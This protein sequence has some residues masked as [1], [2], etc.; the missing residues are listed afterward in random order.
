[1]VRTAKTWARDG[2]AGCF[3]DTNI[4]T[5]ADSSA[6]SHMCVVT[7]WEK[8]TCAVR[9]A[10]LYMCAH[11]RC[12]IPLCAMKP[13]SWILP[14]AL[15]S[16]YSWRARSFL[17]FSYPSSTRTFFFIFRNFLNI[18]FFFSSKEVATHQQFPSSLHWSSPNF[19]DTTP[20]SSHSYRQYV[21][22]RVRLCEKIAQPVGQSITLLAEWQCVHTSRDFTTKER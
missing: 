11:M 17:Q 1:M 9:C 4:E 3:K 21:T 16:P 18:L 14:S 15:G 13:L 22:N 6:L 20:T 2:C 7:R 5:S 10:H 12:H 19:F 8:F